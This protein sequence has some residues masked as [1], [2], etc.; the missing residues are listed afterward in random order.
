VKELKEEVWDTQLARQAQQY[1][2]DEQFEIMEG[3]GTDVGATRRTT[4][5]LAIDP[6]A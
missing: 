3:G 1:S 6:R 5:R 2:C 4:R